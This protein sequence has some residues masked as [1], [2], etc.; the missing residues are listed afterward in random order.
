MTKTK[1]TALLTAAVAGTLLLAGC[2]TPA[3]SPTKTHTHASS[4]TPTPTS[5]IAPA[6][7]QVNPPTSKD[8]ALQSAQKTINGFLG[9]YFE[10]QVDPSLGPHYLDNWISG[11]SEQ[12]NVAA[13]VTTALKTG[14]RVKGKPPVFTAD[15]GKSYTGEVTEGTSTYPNAI[16]YMVGCVDNTGTQFVGYTTPPKPGSFPYSYTVAWVPTLKTWRVTNQDF[17]VTGETC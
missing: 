2:T 13:T 9:H 15:M 12:T 4:P 3:P 10:L 11:A 16:A 5:T 1:L 7:E 6:Q 8:Q 17:N 14:Q